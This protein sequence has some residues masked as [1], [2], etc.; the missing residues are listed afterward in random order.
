MS[1]FLSRGAAVLG[2]CACVFAWAEPA[3]RSLDQALVDVLS[4]GRPNGCGP[5]FAVPDFG[6]SQSDLDAYLAIERDA[7]RI[8]KEIAAICGRSAVTSAAALGGSL[9][10]L[11]TTKTVSQFRAA[12]NRA[13]SRLDARGKR[14]DLDRPILL[15]QAGGLGT[16]LGAS[17]DTS[18]GTDTGAPADGGL[19]LFVQASNERRDRA[20][21]ALEAGYRAHIG[22]VLFGVD[23][24]TR[25]RLIAGAW[26]GYRRADADYRAA[27]LLI[28]GVNAGFGDSL[29]AALQADVCKVGPG[30]GFDD[31]GARFGGFVAKRFDGGFADV[32]VQFSR[33]N[34][35]YRRN[36]CAIEGNSGAI[37]RSATSVSGFASSDSDIDDIYA[38]TIAGKSRLTEWGLSTR[39]GFDFGDDRFQWGPRVSLT[40]L[41]TTIGAYTETGR[42]SVTHTVSSN[43]P[44]VLRTTR[45]AGD[46]IGLEL[47]FDRQRR[48][49]L[50]S[51]LQLVAAYRHQVAFGTVV[52]RL[53]VSW[54][55]EFKGGRELVTV[56]MAQDRRADPTRFSFTTDAVDKSKGS[57]A[58][59]LSWLHGAQFTADIEVSRLFADDRFDATTVAVQAFWRF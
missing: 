32:G 48:T 59:G 35:G 53:A 20:T 3:P 44:A 49:S 10:S 27:N 24:V 29:N 37:V 26:V 7:G 47:A 55:N 23:Y 42:T 45:A 15:A 22:E 33:R 9:G 13:D 25:D 28:G 34:Y 11:Q 36:V 6:S 17:L 8:G 18:S 39:L 38:G 57:F 12:R 52:P 5:A 51:E 41:R 30:G 14:A 58:L 16:S 56:R 31:K 50:Q 2:C 54:L 46:P 1:A 21:T 43:T 40:Y 19:G 4:L